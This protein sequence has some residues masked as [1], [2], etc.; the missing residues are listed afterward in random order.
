MQ[1]TFCKQLGIDNPDVDNS[2]K[3]NVKPLL[4]KC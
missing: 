4:V 2:P 1:T 3:E